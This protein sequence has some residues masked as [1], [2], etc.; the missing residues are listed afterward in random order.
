MWRGSKRKEGRKARQTK[1]GG[2]VGRS[3]RC[4]MGAGIRVRTH[5]DV[6]CIG[7]MACDPHVRRRS[8]LVLQ[9]RVCVWPVHV[10]IDL[11][12]IIQR[13]EFAQ[14]IHL[15]IHANHNRRGPDKQQGVHEQQAK[16]AR[17]LRA[18]VACHGC[19]G[20]GGMGGGVRTGDVRRRDAAEGMRAVR[21]TQSATRTEVFGE[22][23]PLDGGRL[24]RT[25]DRRC[26]GI[27][28]EGGGTHQADS[29]CLL[30]ARTLFGSF[31]P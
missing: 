2:S 3:E 10:S 30:A 19:G 17:Q 15:E 16:H 25:R 11:Q 20:M 27:R 5:L 21:S 13:Y 12:C 8:M 26:D 4:G 31:A 14:R 9:Q 29:S 24:A 18:A 22:E 1:K 28:G 6:L 23:G 7:R